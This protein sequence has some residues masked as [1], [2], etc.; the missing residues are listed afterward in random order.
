MPLKGISKKIVIDIST[1]KPRST[2]MADTE[3]NTNPEDEIDGCGH[4][5][6]S[7]AETVPD[8]DLPATVGGVE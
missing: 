3:T 1:T 6:I 4:E 5:I 7:D 2:K 8:E